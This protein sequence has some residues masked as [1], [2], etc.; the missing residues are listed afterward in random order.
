MAQAL[1]D[2]TWVADIRGALSLVGLTEYLQLLDALTDIVLNH[3]VDRHLWKFEAAGQFSTS[4]LIGPSWLAP[5]PLNLG[6]GYGNLGLRVNAKYLFGW[7]SAI[8]AGLLIA[9]RKEGFLIPSSAA[10]VTRRMRRFS[11]CLH[12]VCLRANSGLAFL[13]L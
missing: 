12:Y 8:V 1:L 7:P 11:T 13:N 9:W 5:S 3:S 10:S 4:R 2:D 6:S